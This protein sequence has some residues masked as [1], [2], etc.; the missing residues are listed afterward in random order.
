[1]KAIYKRLS[2]LE[3]RSG[4]TTGR[5]HRIIQD[6]GQTFQDARAAYEA[7]NGAIV[8]NDNLIVRKIVTP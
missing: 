7:S 4:P 6:I 8:K 2:A 1:M 5:W 3:S